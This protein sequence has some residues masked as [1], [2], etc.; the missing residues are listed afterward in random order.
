MSLTASSALNV[1]VV[2]HHDALRDATVAALRAMGHAVRGVGRAEALAGG[3]DSFRTDLLVVDL[4]LPNGEGI[5]LSRRMRSMQPD[6]GIIAVST[7]TGLDEK[8]AA[9]RG[10]A[11][12]S[13]TKPTSVAEFAAAVDA[14]SRR[15]RPRAAGATK[16]TLNTL[17]LQLQGPHAVVDVSNHECALLLAFAEA[18]ESRLEISRMLELSGKTTDSLG[19]RALEVQIV[20]L[21]KKLADAGATEPAIKAIRGSGYQLCIHLDVRRRPS[22]PPTTIASTHDE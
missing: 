7:Q 18:D 20:R 1:I 5:G 16:M 6:I 21:R 4:D 10:G 19:K 22:A 2:E 8:L 15:I 12:I 13:L 17:T 9:Y 3:L 11:D 14:L